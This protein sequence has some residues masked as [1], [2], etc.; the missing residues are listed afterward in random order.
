MANSNA[1]SFMEII[2]L[3]LKVTKLILLLEHVLKLSFIFFLDFKGVV[4]NL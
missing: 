3:Y 1:M 4:N 2:L